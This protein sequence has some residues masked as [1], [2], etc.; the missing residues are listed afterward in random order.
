M[1]SRPVEVMLVELP[2]DDAG[3]EILA[4]LDDLVERSTISVIDA[5]LVRKG[6]DGGCAAVEVYEL[7]G[8]LATLHEIDGEYGGLV[9]AEDVAL[10]ASAMGP[11]TTCAVLVWEN[12]W[13]E[14]LSSAIDSAGG[15]VIAHDRNPSD[16]GRPP[17][18]RRRY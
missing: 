13:A 11:G 1:S 18:S 14:R 4:A 17:V 2:S 5:V 6:L 10:A 7:A 12:L 16:A 9:S 8:S 15:R 3:P